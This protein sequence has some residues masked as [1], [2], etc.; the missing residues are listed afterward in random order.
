MQRRLTPDQSLFC[1][2]MIEYL[3]AEVE[4]LRAKYPLPDPPPSKRRKHANLITPSEPSSERFITLAINNA[5][6]KLNKYYTLS[7]D[8]VAY[9][10][11]VVF[12]PRQK[13]TFFERSWK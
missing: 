13:W 1:L 2:P 6:V 3:I 9:I 8:S 7:D 4:N 12:N 10:A 5:W 11:D